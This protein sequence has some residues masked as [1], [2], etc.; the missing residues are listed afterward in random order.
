MEVRGHVA[1]SM[2]VQVPGWADSKA[3]WATLR[4]NLIPTCVCQ[5]TVV[6][7]RYQ[8]DIT[9]FSDIN[10]GPAHLPTLSLAK[11]RC[12]TMTEKH[13]ARMPLQNM[14]HPQH[15]FSAW[16]FIHALF[17]SNQPP[18]TTSI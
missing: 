13:L 4:A 14:L 18:S 2:P 8:K 10:P 9:Y 3:R 5:K 11:L 7:Q 6:R 16:S 15:A 12:D 1:M 17:V